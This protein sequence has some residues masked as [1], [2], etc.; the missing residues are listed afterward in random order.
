MASSGGLHLKLLDQPGNE[1]TRVAK[2]HAA[3]ALHAILPRY[4]SFPRRH[5]ITTDDIHVHE[6]AIAHE[7][8]AD[9]P[10]VRRAQR[11]VTSP[12]NLHSDGRGLHQ[13]GHHDAP[14]CALRR[15]DP[16]Q[17][18]GARAQQDTVPPECVRQLP[19]G[20]G[21]RAGQDTSGADTANAAKKLKTTAA[22]APAG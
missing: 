20:R 21:D 11:K 16:G 8:A 2:T 14:A 22:D 3:R 15:L 5:M 10:R 6:V 13:E 4:Q 9:L 18:G 19:D 17:V 12:C 1:D 7:V